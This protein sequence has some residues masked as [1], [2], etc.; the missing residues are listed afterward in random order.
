VYYRDKGWFS[1]RDEVLQN[2]DN[3]KRD[4]TATRMIFHEHVNFM[5]FSGRD[6]KARSTLFV[7]Q[8]LWC[9]IYD[10]DI[11]AFALSF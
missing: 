6:C 3:T 10:H 5:T 8:A 11:T 4:E 1:Y 7:K 9:I 2:D